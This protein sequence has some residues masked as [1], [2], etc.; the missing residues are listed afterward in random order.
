MV[1]SAYSQI[2]N[3]P[4]LDPNSGRPAMEWQVYLA[5][6]G[7][8]L[9]LVENYVPLTGF[10]HQ[11]LNNTNVLAIKPAGG[12]ATGT[13]LMPLSPLPNQQFKISTTQTITALTV[14]PASGQTLNGAVTTLL[15]NTSAGWVFSATD[16]NWYV[17]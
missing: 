12:L 10:S 15:A 7:Y 14:T 16:M 1:M 3:S 4:F 6:L 13:V 9:Q 5:S 8:G 2:P 17:I 11:A